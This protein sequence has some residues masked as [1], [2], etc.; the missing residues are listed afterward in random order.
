MIYIVKTKLAEFHVYNCD[1]L[2][3]KAKTESDAKLYIAKLYEKLVGE[4]IKIDDLK[5]KLI[6]QT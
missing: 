4:K 6:K 1:K 5:V 3:Y 2:K